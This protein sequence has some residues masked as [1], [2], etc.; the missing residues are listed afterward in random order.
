MTTSG[1]NNIQVSGSETFGLT[2]SP[3]DVD[4]V[5]GAIQTSDPS[6]VDFAVIAR[7]KTVGPFARLDVHGHFGAPCTYWGMITPS[8]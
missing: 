6:T 4:N 2:V 3:A 5:S 8:A 7:D 1:Q